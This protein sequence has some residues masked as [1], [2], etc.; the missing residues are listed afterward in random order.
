MH[1]ERRESFRIDDKVHLSLRI[2]SEDEYQRL[3]SELPEHAA[4]EGALMNQLRTLT[5]QTSHLLVNI[6][7]SDPDIANY[8][9]M[10]DRKINMLA[11]H[12]EGSRSGDGM[13]P[14][15]RVNLS[16]GGIGFWRDQPLPRGTKLELRLVLFPS[17]T[18]IRA[19]A[20]VLHAQEDELKPAHLR[21]RM[22]AAFTQ[23]S[24]AE[25]DALVRHLIELQSALLRR[26][27]GR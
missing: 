6:R 25:K 27:R 8:L 2:L 24:E 7:K 13:A 16:A 22:G 14:D 20:Q 17:Y 15:T 12:L 19:L 10:L 4:I 11:A 1:S 23:I 9:G 3:L 21:Y 26:Q 5:A 18:R